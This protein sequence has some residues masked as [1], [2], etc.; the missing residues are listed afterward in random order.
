MSHRDDQID[1]EHEMTLF[2]PFDH[3]NSGDMCSNLTRYNLQSNGSKVAG[4]QIGRFY[5][6][7]LNLDVPYLL[8]NYKGATSSYIKR[9]EM[10]YIDLL[11]FYTSVRDTA[12]VTMMD[13]RE[14]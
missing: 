7:L 11:I 1:G 8:Q 5:R 2:H 12:S 4:C 13:L 3:L 14:H 10:L 6:L 9:T